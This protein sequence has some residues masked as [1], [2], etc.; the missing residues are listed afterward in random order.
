MLQEE[1]GSDAKAVV[2]IDGRRDRRQRTHKH[3]HTMYLKQQTNEDHENFFFATN[4]P[5]LLA[6]KKPPNETKK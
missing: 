6:K 5:I 1:V 2:W 4:K 3:T